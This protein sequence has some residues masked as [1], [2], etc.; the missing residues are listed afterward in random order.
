MCI[1]DRSTQST[2]HSSGT[3]RPAVMS[4]SS[5]KV[6]GCIGVLMLCVLL[7]HRWHEFRYSKYMHEASALLLIGIVCGFFLW[8]GEWDFAFSQSLFW[9][10]V[11]P[12]II[13]NAGY[14]MKRRNFFRHFAVISLLG[15]F[16]TIGST[17]LFSFLMFG[18]RGMFPSGGLGDSLAPYL[19]YGA[20]MTATDSVAVLAILDPKKQEKAHA[21]VFGEGVLNDAITI[22][23]FKTFV[24]MGSDTWDSGTVL[25]VML[26]FVWLLLASTFIGILSGV[27][28]SV[29]IR[30]AALGE[31]HPH[32][33]LLMT[34][35]FAWLSYVL[36]EVLELSAIMSA[37]VC[38]IMLSHYNHYNICLLYTSDAADEE[39]SVD[40]GGRRIIIKKNSR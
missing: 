31:A 10:Y 30:R 19:V 20:V 13:F 12:P 22:V 11:L 14:S 24:D 15:V 5:W 26:S 33:E 7:K 2:G 3:R 40:L 16:A 17:V 8:V 25:G 34:A 38:G 6:I 37:F 23:L 4:G 28:C 21:I 29:A 36:A 39:D 27:V 1:R 35:L 9:D 32:L 18:A